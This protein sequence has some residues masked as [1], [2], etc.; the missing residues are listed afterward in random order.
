MNLVA[1]EL[2]DLLNTFMWPFIRVSAAFLWLQFFNGR[3]QSA[4]ANTNGLHNHDDDLP[5]LD[6]QPADPFTIEGL[7]FALTR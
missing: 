7:G 1:A 4:H 5:W 6:V 2:I 3:Y